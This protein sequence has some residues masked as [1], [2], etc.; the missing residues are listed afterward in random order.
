MWKCL[1][2]WAPIA[3][4]VL[5]TLG[6]Y[7]GRWEVW[8]ET[9]GLHRLGEEIRVYK[10]WVEKNT[11]KGLVFSRKYILNCSAEDR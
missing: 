9:F 8:V 7:G 6:G 5:T 11:T 1:T 10:E 4:E 3:S 2:D